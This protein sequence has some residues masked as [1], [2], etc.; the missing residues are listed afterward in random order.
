MRAKFQSRPALCNPMD[1]S[2]PGSSVHGIL[3]ATVL[4][5]VTISFSRGSSWPRDRICVSCIGRQI[6]CY[7]SHL[8]SPRILEWVA[9]PFSRGS[10]QPRNQTRVSCIAGGYFTSWATRGSCK[11]PL[12]FLPVSCSWNVPFQYISWTWC[13]CKP[14]KYQVI[15]NT[16]QYD[17]CGKGIKLKS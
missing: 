2:P 6:L 10:S 16:L 15:Q 12:Q 14:Q 11:L 4:E 5:W 13:L 1:C 9:Y 7:L 17:Y 8:G 3:W